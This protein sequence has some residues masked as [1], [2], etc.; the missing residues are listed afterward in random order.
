MTIRRI[1]NDFSA[2]GAAKVASGALTN[3][4]VVMC[5]AANVRR[6]LLD[7]VVVG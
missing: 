6:F 2:K 7:N 1:K 3:V 4:D 5:A